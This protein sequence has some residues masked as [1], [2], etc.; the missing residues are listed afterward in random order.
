MDA[1]RS[2]LYPFSWPYSY[3]PVLPS[4]LVDNCESPSPFIFGV[5]SDSFDIVVQKNLNEVKYT[6]LL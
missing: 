3:V 6:Y 1:I 2:L 5:C 4:H